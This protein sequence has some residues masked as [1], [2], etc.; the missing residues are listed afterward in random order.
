MKF[1]IALP[2]FRGGFNALWVIMDRFTKSAH[3]ILIKDSM[4]SD[5]LGQIYIREIMRLYRVPK[6]IVLDKDM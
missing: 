3:L 4:S 6:T 2:R 1:M 5:Q